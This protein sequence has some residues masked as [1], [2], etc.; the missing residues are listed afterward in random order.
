MSKKTTYRRIIFIII[1]IILIIS[2]LGIVYHQ[3]SIKQREAK[4]EEERIQKIYNEFLYIYWFGMACNTS[5]FVSSDD[6]RENPEKYGEVQYS[7]QK[8]EGFEK[9]KVENGIILAFPTINTYAYLENL[10][11]TIE[12][13]DLDITGY[14]LDAPLTIQDIVYKR[15]EIIQMMELTVLGSCFRIDSEQKER[16]SEEFGPDYYF[17]YF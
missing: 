6:I 2:T 4:I 5:R 9:G 15:D 13:Y 7:I 14:G 17:D 3:R 11:F 12:Y 1:A 16:L 8:P 10:N